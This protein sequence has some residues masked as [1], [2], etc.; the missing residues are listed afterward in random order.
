MT[1][2]KKDNRCK[3]LQ[4]LDLLNEYPEFFA[5]N[6]AD[7][8]AEIVSKIKQLGKDVYG[9]Q[10]EITLTPAEFTQLKDDG[11]LDTD[12]ADMQDVSL[13]Y[14]RGWKRQMGLA[15]K[16]N[17]KQRAKVDITVVLQ[18][19]QQGK[20]YREIASH[21]NTSPQYIGLLVRQQEG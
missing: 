16:L 18:M 7:C 21:F 11:Y 4:L 6:E 3:F 19:R 10:P 5:D 2:R 1:Q 8:P 9:K 20:K 13:S 12:I 17:K 15:K 14:L